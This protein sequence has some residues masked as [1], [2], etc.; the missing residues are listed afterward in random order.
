MRLRF[1]TCL[2]P[3]AGGRPAQSSNV[4]FYF[5]TDKNRCSQLL[6]A[7]LRTPCRRE[8]LGCDGAPL[9][10]AARDHTCPYFRRG[11]TALVGAS[12][13]EDTGHLSTPR[14]AR[15][16]CTHKTWQM[17]ALRQNTPDHWKNPWLQKKKGKALHSELPW[18]LRLHAPKAVDVGSIP[19]WGT[20][21]PHALWR[22]Q[23]NLEA[24]KCKPK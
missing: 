9:D 16:V 18:W 22:G 20:K 5:F 15:R 21:I 3:K 11:S 12:E 23:K 17:M 10:S 14:G 24:Q 1:S 6:P 19:D 4:G 13:Q 8:V 7:V 2:P